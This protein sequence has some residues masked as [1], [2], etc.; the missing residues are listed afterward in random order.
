V[1]SI[2][3]ERKSFHIRAVVRSAHRC[4][5]LQHSSG[6]D[7]LV[8]GSPLAVARNWRSTGHFSASIHEMVDWWFNNLALI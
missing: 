1:F 4:P 5:R 7:K 2:F 3:T 8:R 6:Q